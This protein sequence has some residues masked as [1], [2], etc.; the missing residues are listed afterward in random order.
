MARNEESDDDDDDDDQY[1]PYI[2]A[3]QISLSS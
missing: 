2:E 1:Y 3:P